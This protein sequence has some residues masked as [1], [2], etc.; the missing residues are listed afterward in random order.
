MDLHRWFANKVIVVTGS[1]RGIGRETARLALAA[2]A[3][4]VVNGR[5]PAT[6]AATVE[7][8]G[9][10]DRTL[11]VAADLSRPAEAARLVATVLDAWGRI[12][13]VVNNA[14]LS[15]RG[16]FADLSE[17][18]VRTM[19]DANLLS[20]VWT[21]QAALP[22]LRSSQG[23]VLFVSSLAGVRGFAGVSLYSAAKLALSAVND[24]VQAEEGPHGVRSGLIW[25]AFTENDPD[26]TVVGADGSLFRHQRRWSLTQEQTARRILEALARGR[27]RTVLTAQGR[28]L[29]VAQA[30]FPTLVDGVLARSG[31]RVHAVKP[32][33]APEAPGP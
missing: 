11:A 1:A 18:T 10:P 13:A 5:N 7:A 2:G 9:H 23:R 21:T 19:V 15:M 17:A 26:K 8:L 3:R 4:V 22:A 28:L 20:A 32:V 29:A 27:R 14:G 25:L 31:G 24:A 33:D 12:D 30:L 16:G 6:L